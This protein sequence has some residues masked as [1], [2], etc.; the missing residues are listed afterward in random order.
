MEA[1]TPF[2]VDAAISKLV[3]D[4]AECKGLLGYV[5]LDLA[6]LKQTAAAADEVLAIEQR[7]DGLINN[8]GI[9][10]VPYELTE[11]GVERQFQVNHLSHLLFT[12]KLLPM[13]EKTGE[14]NGHPAQVINLS[15][16]AHNFISVYSAASPSYMDLATVNRRFEPTGFIRYS[17]AKLAAILF[18]REFNKRVCPN[19]RSLTV[20]PGFLKSDLYKSW[21]LKPFVGIFI[22]L[23]RGAWLSIYAALDPEVEEKDLWGS[24]LVPF[25]Q[26]Q[27]TTH[28]G[29][30][31]ALAKQCWDLS[32]QLVNQKVGEI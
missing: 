5:K 24:D 3:E 16:F 31:P 32:E 12:V 25:C 20:H 30:D 10:A 19:V 7:L 27:K 23:E 17:Q 14:A 28:A 4:N 9:M 18:L 11:D 21:Y 8:A 26:V 6:S 13:L 29:E 22:P 1:R 15:S 2:K